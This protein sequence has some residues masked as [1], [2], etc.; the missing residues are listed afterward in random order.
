MKKIF[1]AFL[2]IIIFLSGCSSGVQPVMYGKDNCEH[3]KM[4]IMNNHFAA[5]LITTK[6]KVFKFDDIQC[7]SMYIKNTPVAKNSVKQLFITDYS[8]PGK[9]INADKAGF[10]KSDSLRS[11]ME[12]NIA[13]FENS[14]SAKKYLLQFQ[15][16]AVDL[17]S[18]I[19]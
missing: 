8:V 3:C 5:E 7:L 15:A 10:I 17:N 12:G 18:I 1:F 14:D 13:A 2:I 4:T 19:P 6:G 16:V 9:F 11:P